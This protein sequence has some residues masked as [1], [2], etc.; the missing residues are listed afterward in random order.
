MSELYLSRLALRRDASLAALASFFLPETS[1]ERVVAAHRLIWSAFSDGPD[2]KR[3]FLW[4]HDGKRRWFVLSRRLPDDPHALF[5]IESNSFEP[6]LGKGDHLIFALRANAVVTRKDEQG[7]AKRY[8]IVMDRLRSFPKGARASERARLA[9][10]ASQDWL[11][12]QGAKAGF[13]LH[14]AE[15]MA[16]RTEKIPRGRHKQ[17]ELGLLDLEGELTIEQ[18]D[19]FLPALAAGFGKAKG[20]GCG[21]M[22]I[23]RS[24]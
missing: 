19:L 8:D 5:D 15:V 22:L 21:L 18:P 2:R 4:R 13:R 11:T 17:I 1:G 14:Q 10:E 3:D 23:R 6:A 24:R 9:E 16:Y 20:F 12:Q 7:R